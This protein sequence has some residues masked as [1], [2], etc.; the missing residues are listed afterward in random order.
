M[1]L[2]GNKGGTM[3]KKEIERRISELNVTYSQEKSKLENKLF[4]L[5][6]LEKEM[7]KICLV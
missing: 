2:V 7:K 4:E 5:E 1:W 3:T 6:Q